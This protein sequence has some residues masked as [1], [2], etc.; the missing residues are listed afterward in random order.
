MY[1][2]EFDNLN[3]VHYWKNKVNKNSHKKK[4]KAKVFYNF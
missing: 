2:N 4:W 3:E 1:A